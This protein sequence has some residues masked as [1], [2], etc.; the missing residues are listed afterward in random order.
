[1]L[2]IKRKNAKLRVNAIRSKSREFKDP[3][4]GRRVNVVLKNLSDSGW[5]EEA[6]GI[7][8]QPE[9]CVGGRA[10]RGR[11]YKVGGRRVGG[12]KARVGQKRCIG[13]GSQLD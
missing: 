9:I 10:W 4:R 5:E 3:E 7:A 11:R 1:M 2:V 6:G 8:K 12:L 13:K